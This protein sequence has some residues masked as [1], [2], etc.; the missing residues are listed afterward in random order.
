MFDLSGTSN[1]IINAFIHISIIFSFLTFLFIYIIV[2]LSKQAFNSN[3]DTLIQK[4]IDLA[5]PNPINLTDET[6]FVNNRNQLINQIT[7]F[8][9]NYFLIS[10]K[11]PKKTVE[12]INLISNNIDYI[13]KN[14]FFYD[15]LLDTYKQPNY[16][17]DTH[18]NGIL[19]ISIYI[20]ITLFI[21]SIIIIIADK[22]SCSSCID[23]STILIENF[24]VF[25]FVGIAE[26]L[27][28]INYAFKYHP[29]PPSTLI[30]TSIQNIK[31][32]L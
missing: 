12:I 15:Q 30:N 13:V 16:I 25:I 22:M 9:K 6:N 32:L 24:F 29:V 7:F 11:D 28:F 14:K 5:I 1:F 19:N 3:I 26:Y 10:N 17:I 20:S 8:L 2:P 4:Q 31:N 23:L 21:I 27:F 18:N